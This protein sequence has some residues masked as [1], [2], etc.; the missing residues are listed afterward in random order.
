M[1]E[2]IDKLYDRYSFRLN[3]KRQFIR[4]GAIHYFRLPSQQLWRDRL[5]KLKAAGYNTVD[6]YFNWGYHSLSQG[7]YDFSGIRDVSA[8]LEMAKALGLWVIARPGP[9]INAE[10]S[11]GGFPMWL[12]AKKQLPLRNRREGRF[13]WSDEYMAYVRQWW[14]QI[15][16]IVN[17]F[18]NVLML[19][20]ENEYSTLEME[21]DYMQALYE[22]ARSL[23]VTV[24]LSHNDLFIAGLYADI[25][26]L[27]AF[28][29]Y[30][31][32]QFETDWK[33]M[34]GVFSVLDHVEA[35]IRSF[36]Q[37]RPLIAAELQAG[38][39]GMWRGLKYQD[40]TGSLGREHI[41]VSTKTL[42]AQGLTVFNHYK[43]IGGTNW[44]HIG[45]TETYTSYDFGAPISETG[46]NTIRLFE[47]KALNYLLESFDMAATERVSDLSALPFEVEDAG[48]FL[49]GVRKNQETEGYWLF[50][51]NLEVDSN[52]EGIV[53]VT[54]PALRRSSEIKIN[55]HDMLALPC[56]TPLACGLELL[57]TSVEPV[58]QN[59]NFLFVKGH[60][61]IHMFFRHSEAMDAEVIST[62]I[63]EDHALWVK[64]FAGNLVEISAEAMSDRAIEQVKITFGDKVLTLVVLGRHW[65]DRFWQDEASLGENILMG[66][67]AV[68]SDATF[69]VHPSE[70]DIYR[71][72][73]DDTYAQNQNGSL[74]REVSLPRVYPKLAFP[75]LAEWEISNAAPELLD[76]DASKASLFS[77][78]SPEGLDLDAN[79]QFEGSA[80]YDV[81]LGS[82]KPT[83]IELQASHLWAVYLNGTFV[84]KGHY[85]QLIHGQSENPLV[86][87]D[88][89]VDAFKAE[90]NRL[91]IFVD[92]LG[93]PK[94]FHDDQQEAAGLLKLLIDGNEVSGKELAQS[95]FSISFS[96]GLANEMPA[97]QPYLALLANE[98]DTAVPLMYAKTCFEL[99]NLSDWEAPLGVSMP[100]GLGCDRVNVYINGVLI[101]RYWKD[102]DA[103][104]TFYLPEGLLYAVPGEHNELGL[105]CMAFDGKTM[106][107]TLSA[108]L[109]D[110]KAL[111]IGAYE[112]LYKFPL[113][114][115]QFLDQSKQ[116]K[117]SI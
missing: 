63:G 113:K 50:F 16:P 11:G 111:S 40:I 53:R 87:I 17:A 59:K 55:A 39:F 78:V 70:K 6:I 64:T 106:A 48:K 36:C 44:G 12:L 104:Q 110:A 112:T 29:N 68:L 37:D 98:S 85:L 30:S 46:M 115:T 97:K 33:K 9:Y 108:R 76:A 19:Q 94:G 43:A 103:Q 75:N 57:F 100:Q 60:Y 7:V 10:V 58:Y 88:L 81:L 23:G 34:S 74:I 79:G 8:L 84:A 54:F 35:N 5:Y 25:V 101:G 116:Q 91:Q 66:P 18:D 65:A 105:L 31:V 47:V 69:A 15:L 26:D 109:R 90:E 117:E 86:R 67:D 2:P 14:S 52:Q 49:Y 27:Y 96:G 28:D 41:N 72:Y 80:W 61:P 93:H 92:G 77:P 51:R 73:A 22:M 38:W 3:G 62:R 13:E 99:P 71:L 82:K 89:P 24:P 32:T 56:M 21:P 20:I 1:S 83:T 45:S 114:P 102:C 42:L 95:G 4:S 107:K